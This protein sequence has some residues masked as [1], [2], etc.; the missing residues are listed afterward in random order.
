MGS[1]SDRVSRITLFMS[2]SACS[3]PLTR[4]NLS[5]LLTISEARNAALMTLSS[6]GL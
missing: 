6:A 2:I 3:L 5:R 1:T 4:E